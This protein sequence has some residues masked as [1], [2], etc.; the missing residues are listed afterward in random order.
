LDLLF[1]ALSETLLEVARRKLKAR[2]GFFAVLH[3]WTQKLLLHPHLHCVVPGGGLSLT[4]SRWVGSGRRFFLPVRIL[5][6]VF[7]GKLLS[8]LEKALAEGTI[9]IP[10]GTGRL[11][12][13]KASRVTWVVYAK[14]PLAGPKHVVRY[15]SRYTKRI[16]ISNSRLV[17]YD[18]KTVTFF[19]RDRAHK[20]RRKT[21][22]LPGLDFARRFLQHVLPRRFVRI[23]H[24]GLLS[25]RGTK[26]LE[27][28]R[29]LLQAG[30]VVSSSSQ[31]DKSE[32]W[33][34]SFERIFGR[35]PLLCPAC[36][37]GRLVPLAL[38]PFQ[39]QPLPPR[40]PPQLPQ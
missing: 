27:E 25:N 15:V 38:L 37:E 13:E 17:A 20:N 9:P 24:Y 5:R 12:L 31:R 35:D 6:T 29:S 8:K 39:A 26:N 32:D 3:T 2:I 28:C 10:A 19:W 11:L 22:S 14:A 30:H 18:G 21:L 16:A 40:S 7:R 1:E 4:S 34:Q 33:V 23:R 36:G